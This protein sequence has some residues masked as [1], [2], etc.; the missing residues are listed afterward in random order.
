M[1]KHI[2]VANRMRYAEAIIEYTK[3]GYHK[4]YENIGET[5]MV[6]GKSRATVIIKII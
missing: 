1:T 2:D 6:K 3:K 5:V 4:T